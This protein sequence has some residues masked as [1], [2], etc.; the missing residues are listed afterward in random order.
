[1]KR[2]SMKRWQTLLAISLAMLKVVVVVV[3]TILEGSLGSGMRF[4]WL[5]FKEPKLLI[6]SSDAKEKGYDLNR[7]RWVERGSDTIKV[8][9]RSL[10][11]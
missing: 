7:K 1:M 11:S 9:K 5:N 4:D 2:A 8:E 6:A 3:V 10:K